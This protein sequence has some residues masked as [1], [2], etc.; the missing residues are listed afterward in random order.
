[1]KLKIQRAHKLIELHSEARDKIQQGGEIMKK[2]RIVAGALPFMAVHA[3]AIA[4]PFFMAFRW[5][6]IPLVVVVYYFRMWGV[7]IGYH[8]FFAHK[9]FKTSRTFQYALAF[10]AESSA[11]KG[12]AWWAG[13]HREHHR[14]D[15]TDTSRDIHTPVGNG[16][17]WSH[18][19]WIFSGKYNETRWDL[20][21]DIGSFPELRWLSKYHLVPPV[22]LAVST[23]LTGRLTGNGWGDA[24]SLL[25][26]GF[27]VTTAMLWHGSFCIN[28]LAHIRMWGSRKLWNTPFNTFD[29][30]VLNVITGG[31][32]WH[33]SHHAHQAAAK[34]GER[35]Q[36]EPTYSILCLLAWVGVVWDLKPRPTA[37][38][39]ELLGGA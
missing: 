28:S 1:V 34:Q 19:G 33:D 12:I 21:S 18:V 3:I 38:R 27:F 29:S 15:V 9:A 22:T 2:I 20:V 35:N 26:W 30:M 32:G 23:F 8:R 24:F 31:E 13:W 7:T 11:Q 36:M 25:V 17:W 4:A 6:Y 39:Y 37:A 14:P 16:F 10:I 5:W